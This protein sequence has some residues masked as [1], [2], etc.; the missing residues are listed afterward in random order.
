MKEKQFLKIHKS[1][2]EH[3]VFNNVTGGVA[4]NGNGKDVSREQHES[5]VT[6]DRLFL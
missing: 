6:K 2:S 3:M 5:K 1:I 4:G